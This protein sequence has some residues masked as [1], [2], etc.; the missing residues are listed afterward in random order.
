MH[1]RY[2]F[3]RLIARYPDL[4]SVVGLWANKRDITKLPLGDFR[5]A[6]VATSLA[7]AQKQID[8]FIPQIIID[9]SNAA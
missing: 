7:E 5:P 8:Q 6:Q 2:V 4:K 9:R 1:A 3:K